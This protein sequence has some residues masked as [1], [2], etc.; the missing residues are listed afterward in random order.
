MGSA[1]TSDAVLSCVYEALDEGNEDR[2]S[3]DLPPL[4]KSP[5]TPIH[6]TD[7]GFDS[8]GLINFVIAVEE[9]LER[10]FGVPVVL[11][12]DRALDREPSPFETVQTLVE[13]IDVL[14]SEQRP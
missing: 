8:L 10:D 14:L 2:L 3:Q 9:G 4:E 1:I 6:G 5:N 12:D 11:S 13:Y 7:S